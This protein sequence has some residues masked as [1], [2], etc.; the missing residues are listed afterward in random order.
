MYNANVSVSYVFD[1]FGG[2]R[3]AI[4][5]LRAQ[6]DFERYELEATYLTLA[7]NI[8]TT[9][10]MEASLR[11][12]IKQTK[13]IIKIEEKQLALAKQRFKIGSLTT[14]DVLAQ[15]TALAQTAATLPP[16]E[17][18]LAQTRHALAV[19]VG[20]YPGD[21]NLPHFDLDDLHLPKFTG[22]LAFYTCKTAP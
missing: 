22:E 12:Q 6:M 7:G 8:A 9:A 21:K 13:K 11:E 1:I 18:T 15:E 17:D 14:I 19:L 5:G 4:E 16:L 3:R 10:I 20:H 2:N